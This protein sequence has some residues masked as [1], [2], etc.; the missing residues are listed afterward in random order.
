MFLLVACGP[1]KP[2]PISADDA[3]AIVRDVR[4]LEATLEVGDCIREPQWTAPIRALH[5]L[6]VCK[7]TD[8]VYI[9]TWSRFVESRGYWIAPDGTGPDTT[10]GADPAIRHIGGDLY[11]Y[12]IKG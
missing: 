12:E 4:A 6:S 3:D 10:R 2:A 11:W 9:E 5:P 7:A 1:S 8:G